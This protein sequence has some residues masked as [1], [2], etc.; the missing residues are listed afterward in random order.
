MNN[1][2]L[3]IFILGN[4]RRGRKRAAAPGHYRSPVPAANEA[5]RAEN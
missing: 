2:Y 5:G 1:E 4:R 3:V